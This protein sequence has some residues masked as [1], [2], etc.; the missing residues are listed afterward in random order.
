MNDKQEISTF[1]FFLFFLDMWY[2]WTEALQ[3][4]FERSAP[5]AVN[6]SKHH[7]SV[8]IRK[9]LVLLEEAGCVSFT[10]Q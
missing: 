7:V 3:T 6:A 9:R 10:A 2:W 1:S 8:T 4:R 5:V